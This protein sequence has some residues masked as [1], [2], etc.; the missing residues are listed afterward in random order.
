MGGG[1]YRSVRG[2]EVTRGSW[3][4][5]CNAGGGGRKYATGVACEVRMH[6]EGRES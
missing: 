5:A 2:A 6:G 1:G 4:W 3:G